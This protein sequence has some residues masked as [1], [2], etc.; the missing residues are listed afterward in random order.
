[1]KV[2]AVNPGHD[3]AIAML[4]GGKLL[5]SVEAEKDS[6]ERHSP[7]TAWV[8]HDALSHAPC[9]PDVVAVG[10]WYKLLPG[11]LADA[12][13]G[14]R[15]L[16]PGDVRPSRLFGRQVREFHS[17]HERSHIVGALA[18]SPFCTEAEVAVLVW[19]GV[20]GSLYRWSP[21]SGC[22]DTVEVLDQ[23]GARYAA[24]F[25]LADPHFPDD[26]GW[27][28]SEYAGKLMALAGCADGQDCR[29]ESREVVQALLG[30]RALYPYAKGRF[31]HSRLY[32]AGPDHP[33][34][35]RAARYLTDELFAR[36]AAAARGF[37]PPGL[38]LVVA[39]GCGLN[40]EWNSRW[41][42]SG[43]F[44]DVFVPPCADDSGAAIGA[45]AD[46]LWQLDGVT[47][48]EW[49]VYAGADFVH[50]CD[51]VAAG[52][53]STPLDLDHVVDALE[54][55]ET[56]AWVQGRC[57][58]GP[59][60]LGHRSLLAS[61]TDGASKDHLNKVK[62]R[63]WYRPVAPACLS[64]ELATWF[65]PPH[66]DPFMLYFSLVRQPDRVP[67]I[68]HMDGTAR[69][70]AVDPDV[71]RLYDLLRT[72][73]ALTGV[74]MVCNTSLNFHGRGFVNRMSDLLHLCR[75]SEIDLVVVDDAMLRR[76]EA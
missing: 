5:F 50:D 54:A 23:P 3:G 68:V 29:D 75:T 22:L 7:L 41:S 4:D 20:I 17:S 15:G 10:G 53:T 27:P 58:I 72:L 62:G 51:P 67:A 25:A 19:E 6:V 56:V 16:A 37:F 74:P 38:P 32:N 60:A 13:G 1:M 45:A 73:H 30:M 2:L 65:D 64:S 46:A 40:C 48:I 71:G 63:E 26:G 33:E 52:W 31:R 49:S 8:V 18:L 14:Y 42:A 76:R 55:G 9:M 47:P 44:R 39:G 69:A 12:G 11:R 66:A 70:Q 57:E 43:L 28:A 59:R 35:M 61:A 24:L 36:Y 34:V 21:A